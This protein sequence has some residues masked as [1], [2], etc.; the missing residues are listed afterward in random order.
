MGNRGNLGAEKRD[1]GEGLLKQ[2][3]YG[4][5]SLMG[6]GLYRCTSRILYQVPI[7]LGF[8]SVAKYN[9]I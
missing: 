1:P 5:T 8:L 7:C 4:I 3:C 2:H 9:I 6:E